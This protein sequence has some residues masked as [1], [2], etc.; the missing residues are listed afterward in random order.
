MDDRKNLDTFYDS[1]M[2]CREC[3][4]RIIFLSQYWGYPN[5]HGR[6]IDPGHIRQELAART[7]PDQTSA[8]LDEDGSVIR[9]GRE[10][11]LDRIFLKL[12]IETG[13]KRPS[14]GRAVYFRKYLQLQ[15]EFKD[16]VV[17]RYGPWLFC[18]GPQ[19]TVLRNELGWERRPFEFQHKDDNGV[20][21]DTTMTYLA[22]AP[23]DRNGDIAKK[24]QSLGMVVQDA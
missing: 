13:A 24:V 18:Y 1:F 15:K 23:F 19:A 11:Q 5:A 2:V 9:S 3:G 10:A 7:A 21:F 14:F 6:I 16:P 12:K 4:E 20:V 8:E 22:M 17:L